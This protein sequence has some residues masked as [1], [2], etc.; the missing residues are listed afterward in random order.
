MVSGGGGTTKCPRSLV[1]LLKET[2]HIERTILPEHNV[3]RKKKIF[4]PGH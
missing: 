1:P 2:R 3:C 4:L